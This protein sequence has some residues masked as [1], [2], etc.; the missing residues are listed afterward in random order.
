M[1][2]KKDGDIVKR[3]KNSKIFE[4]R[5]KESYPDYEILG[6]YRDRNTDILLRCKIHNIEFLAKPGNIFKR[7]L[8]PKCPECLRRERSKNF[9][10]Y[11]K[12]NYPNID[13][14]SAQKDFVDYYT[15]IKLICNLHPDEEIILT[16]E[17]IVGKNGHTG[18][19]RLF[20][21]NSCKSS[22]EIKKWVDKFNKKFPKHC[23]D[24]SNSTYKIYYSE[25]GNGTARIDNIYCKDCGDYFSAKAS[26]LYN[27]GLCPNCKVKSQGETFVEKWLK[28]NNLTF[29]SQVRISN[30]V[31]QGKFENSD[32]IVDFSLKHDNIIYWIEYNGEQHYTWCKHFQT[33]EKFEGQLRRD[34]NIREYCRLNSIVLVEIPYKYYT[35]DSVWKLLDEIVLNKK[36][37]EE[38]IKLPEINY[39]RGGNIN[40]Q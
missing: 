37:P 35:Q 33:L 19:P 39:N 23:F 20:L 8:L 13:Y 26:I 32:V 5:L 10:E 11:I 9:I 15:P 12:I 40:G 27:S 14:F 17:Q 18:L 3:Q 25:N 30:K 38:L 7:S 29:N 16:P 21:C 31:I 22:S 1:S 24:F 34:N 6:E 2:K 4:T 28:S 36:S